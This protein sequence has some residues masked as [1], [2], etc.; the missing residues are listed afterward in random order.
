MRHED[1]L[2]TIRRLLALGQSPNEHEAE[3][4]I[5]KA[6][7]LMRRHNL[8]QAALEAVELDD[9][10]ET[11]TASETSRMPLCADIVG[12]LLLEFF[13][14]EVV[15]F[16][17]DGKTHLVIFGRPHNVMI[18]NYVYRYVLER[19]AALAKLRRIRRRDRKSYYT[20]VIFGYAKKLLAERLATA[21]PI[22]EN[23]LVALQS[24]VERA[25]ER[26]FG[27]TASKKASF[28]DMSTTAFDL[29]VH[30]GRTITVSD[31]LTKSEPRSS[32]PRQQRLLASNP[33]P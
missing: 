26:H 31:A 9:R 13:F 10:W 4:A 6:A 2:D 18:A 16:R 11:R 12:S 21:T 8:S 19:C 3:A 17:R 25:R 30:D 20:G 23:A 33:H 24:E 28:G 22:S 15:Y 32:I 14:V 29:G 5:A 7:E 1:L 27:E